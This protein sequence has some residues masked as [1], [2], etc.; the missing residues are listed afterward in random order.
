MNSE[1]LEQHVFFGNRKDREIFQTVLEKIFTFIVRDIEVEYL[2][3]PS[4]IYSTV[5]DRTQKIL[6]SIDKPEKIST[7]SGKFSDGGSFKLI[8]GN[9][10]VNMSEEEYNYELLD[11]LKNFLC[12]VFPLWMFKSPYIWGATVY[13]DYERQHFFEVRKYSERSLSLDLPEID[14]YR[15]DNGIIHKYRFFPKEEFESVEDGFKTLGPVFES[16][17]AGLL[18]R[19]YEGLEIF[20]LYCTNRP[21]FRKTEPRTKLGKEMKSILS[22]DK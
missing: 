11:S 4:E 16:L 10:Y 21:L 2:D 7:F 15:R 8:G 19:N 14:I 9:L 22:P 1:I 20:S 6:F 18:K 12:P 3:R 5:N 17:R 13:E